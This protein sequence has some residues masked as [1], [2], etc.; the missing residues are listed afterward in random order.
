MHKVRQATLKKSIRK[1]L[2]R[3]NSRSYLLRVKH[4]QFTVNFFSHCP[5][6]QEGK[7]SVIKVNERRKKR[8]QKETLLHEIERDIKQSFKCRGL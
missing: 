2:I 5:Q 1:K 3:F 4:D 6:K 8:T 7:K